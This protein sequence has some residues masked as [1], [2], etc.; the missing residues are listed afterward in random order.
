M[1]ADGDAPQN[2]V[3]LKLARERAL[4]KLNLAYAT[5]LIDDT[6]LERRIEAV[7]AASTEAAL[8]ALVRD[9]EG[10]EA[11]A[12]VEPVT[13]STALVP[14]G[15]TAPAVMPTSTSL[16]PL[17][18]APEAGRVVSIFSNN[19][20][21]GRFT[22]PRKLRVLSIFGNTEIDLREAQFAPGENVVRATSVFGNIEVVVPPGL[23]VLMDGGGV[24]GNFEYDGEA[25]DT[26]DAPAYVRVAGVA[27]LGNVEITER[28]PGE[29]ARQARKR[30]K[31]ERKALGEAEAQRRLEAHTAGDAAE[32]RALPAAE[33][34]ALPE[35]R[36]GD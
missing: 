11:L 25:A 1:P 10:V 3:E 19:E 31:R 18:E 17:G 23:P 5:D 13:T 12:G 22:L 26:R 16:V 29:S 4:E 28:L 21:R 9:L 2:L 6:E 36:D 27:V 33:R 14:T 32:Q 30:R 34:R 8:T 15:E 7:Q 35:H 20:R 24:L